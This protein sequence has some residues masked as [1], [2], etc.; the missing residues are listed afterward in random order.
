M[1]SSR[2]HQRILLRIITML[3]KGRFLS[4][5]QAARLFNCTEQTITV[6]LNELR[7]DGHQIRYSRS[8]QRFVIKNDLKK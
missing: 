3:K 7:E 6:W 8:L 1:S 5:G 2:T 4:R